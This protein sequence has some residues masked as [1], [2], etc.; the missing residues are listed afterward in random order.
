VPPGKI[1]YFFSFVVLIYISL[2]D[3]SYIITQIRSAAEFYGLSQNRQ[4]EFEVVS[5]ELEQYYN[6]SVNDQSLTVP[7]ILEGTPCVIEHYDKYYRVIIK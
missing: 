4:H 2:A 7:V 6:N 5:K 1:D 3:G